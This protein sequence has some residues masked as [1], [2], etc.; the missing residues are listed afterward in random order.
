MEGYETLI[1][2]NGS[3]FYVCDTCEKIGFG[4]NNEDTMITHVVT[5]H[6]DEVDN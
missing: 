5:H 4:S 6:T 1:R 3:K 2:K